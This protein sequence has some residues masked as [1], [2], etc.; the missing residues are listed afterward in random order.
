MPHLMTPE[1]PR[2]VRIGFGAILAPPTLKAVVW[3]PPR[4]DPTLKPAIFRQQV[5][6][7]LSRWLEINL[8]EPRQTG[9]QL[10]HNCLYIGWEAT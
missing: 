10:A 8:D 3:S 2:P 9:E 6:E 5:R 4:E 7:E 1:R